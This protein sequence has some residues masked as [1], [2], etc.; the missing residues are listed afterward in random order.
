MAFAARNSPCSNSPE[1][2]DCDDGGGLAALYL[3]K[4]RKE[5][6]EGRKEVTKGRLGWQKG[7]KERVRKEDN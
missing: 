6:G 1:N 5:G 4:G 3:G 2:D 7:R